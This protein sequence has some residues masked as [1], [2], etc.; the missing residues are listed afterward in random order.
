GGGVGRPGRAG[1]GGGGGENRVPQGRRPQGGGGDSREGPA[2]A[3][4][5]SAMRISR[6]AVASSRCWPRIFVPAAVASAASATPAPGTPTTRS[7]IRPTAHPA[8]SWAT[9]NFA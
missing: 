1:G 3:L 9:T 8:V 2:I 7:S 6:W 5:L 4:G